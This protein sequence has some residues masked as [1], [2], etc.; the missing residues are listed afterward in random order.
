MP[1]SDER[2]PF[3]PEVYLEQASR[4][5]GVPVPAAY[6]EGVARNLLLIAGMAELV[7]SFSLPPTEE[8]APVF[9]PAG[10]ER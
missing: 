10:P 7:M 2:T 8:P 6:R 4:L 3:D 5:A 9:L 1:A